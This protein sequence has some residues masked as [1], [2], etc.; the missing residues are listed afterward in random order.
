MKKLALLLG[1]LTFV[2]VVTAG[3]VR[4]AKPAKPQPMFGVGL[5]R[6]QVEHYLDM[7]VKYSRY[8]KPWF[9][10]PQIDIVDPEKWRE[11]V[12]EGD[13]DCGILGYTSDDERDVVHVIAVIPPEAVDRLGW[14]RDEIIVHELVHWLQ[15]QSGQEY[16]IEC[17]MR[18]AMETEAYNTQFQY[19]VQELHEDH[20]FWKPNVY[21][22]CLLQKMMRGRHASSQPK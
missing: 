15:I 1:L 21:A 11:Q 6:E 12:C 5:N 13:A 20:Q 3:A 10:R 22:G 2:V 14:S 18:D 8:R 9:V 7:A 4:I 17:A 19:S 16:P